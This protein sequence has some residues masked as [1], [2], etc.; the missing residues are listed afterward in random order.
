MSM[1]FIFGDDRNDVPSLRSMAVLVGRHVEIIKAGERRET[2][3]RLVL[4]TKPPYYT[5]YDAPCKSL[6]DLWQ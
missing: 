3:R 2:A 4:P 1:R 6:F 5:G